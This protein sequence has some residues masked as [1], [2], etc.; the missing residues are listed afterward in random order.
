MILGLVAATCVTIAPAAAVPPLHADAGLFG[1]WTNT[2]ATTPIAV[3]KLVISPNGSGGLFVDTF[4]TC[5]GPA[6]CEYGRVQAVVFGAAADSTIGRS[7]EMNQAFATYNKILFGHLVNTSAGPRITVQRYVAYKDSSRTNSALSYTFKKVSSSTAGTGLGSGSTAYPTGLQPTP[8][9][10]LLGTWN[11]TNP[12][13]GGLVKVIVTH[14]AGNSLNVH[15][16]GK[17]SP[18]P[19][20]IGTFT[21]IT[22]GN[23]SH[24]AAGSRFVAPHD[25]G[26]N[27][28]LY[29]GQAIAANGTLR[30]DYYSQ[31]TDS[32]GRTNFVISETFSH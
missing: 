4:G 27:R 10:S 2:G 12:N 7:F 14:G 17:C 1:T 21:G 30:L 18:N 5:G 23:A 31:Y 3:V 32:S 29:V 8:T 11:N 6:L 26:F 9:G 28:E 22:Y 20:D 24:A 13:T 19:C 25:A 15:S 16:F